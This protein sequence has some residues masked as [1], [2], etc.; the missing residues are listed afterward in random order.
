MLVSRSNLQYFIF[1]CI[2]VLHFPYSFIIHFLIHSSVNEHLGCFHDMAVVNSSAV[3]NSC[4]MN[5]GV[6][7]SF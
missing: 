2:Y 4:A 1:C 7:V 6:H 3:V 5:I